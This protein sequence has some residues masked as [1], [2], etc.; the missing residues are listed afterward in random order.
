MLLGMARPSGGQG[1]VL[2][3][4]IDDPASSV[5]IRL[6][7]GFVSDDKDLY[8]SMAAGDLIRFTARFFP[9]WNRDLE[10]QYVRR[11]E[12]PLA[13]AVRTLSRG[14]RA[15]LALLLALCRGADLLV[16]DEPTAGLDPAVTEDVLQALVAHVAGAGATVFF[17]SH[18]IAEI[19]QIADRVA[20]IDKGRTVLEGSLDELRE[21]YRRVQLVF[22][23]DPPEAFGALARSAGVQRVRRSGR[24]VTVMTNGG[25]DALVDQARA[26]RP[27]AIDVMPVTLKEMFLETV[28]ADES[29]S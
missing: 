13:A 26:F 21:R 27:A 20:M 12:I 6:R 4:P 25:A 18:Q 3:L 19:E 11:L 16:L 15:K 14:G 9:K 7:T 1:R 24:V 5:A 22:D 28:G 29:G 8:E 2:G 17:S 23:G 10:R